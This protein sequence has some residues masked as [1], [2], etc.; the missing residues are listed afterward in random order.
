MTNSTIS[1]PNVTS[2]TYDAVGNEAKCVYPGGMSHTYSYNPQN[3]LLQVALTNNAGTQLQTYAYGLNATGARTNVTESLGTSVVRQIIYG[4]DGGNLPRVSRL[5]SETYYSNT[6]TNDGSQTYAYDPV[7]NRTNRTVSFGFTP[8]DNL[9]NQAF[10]FD[11]RDQIDSDGW[12]NNANP[13]YDLNGNSVTTNGVPDGAKYDAENR[14][15]SRGTNIQIT[16]DTDG[17]RI[18]KTVGG[19][20]TTYLVDDQNPTGYPQVLVEWTSLSPY[21]GT[22]ISYAYGLSLISQC[23][24]GDDI[25]Y[26]ASDGQGSTRMLL[27]GNTVAASFDY[28]GYG[29]LLNSTNST[30]SN[31]RYTGQQWDPDLQQYYLRA[32]Y[33]DPKLGR[34]WTIDTYDGDQTDPL[35]LHKYLYC[36]ANPA[37]HIDPSG[38]DMGDLM[39]SMGIGATIGGLSSAVANVAEGRAI[40]ARSV[41]E[42]AALGAV[43]GPLAGYIPAVGV[44]L[45]VGGAVY[46]GLSYGPTL[47]DPNATLEQREASAVL[48]FASIYGATAGMKYGEISENGTANNCFVS[49]TL[50]MEV[51]GYKK[52]ED[53]R[54]GDS[55]WSW[56]VEKGEII[57]EPVRRLFRRSVGELA[58]LRFGTNLLETTPQHRFW[59]NGSG[60]REAAN[61]CSGDVLKTLD[62]NNLELSSMTIE[63]S[64]NVVFNF[65]VK[66][67]HTYFVGDDNILTHNACARDLAGNLE[68]VGEPRPPGTDAHHIVARN[69]VR[70]TRARAILLREQIDL[71][72]AANGAFLDSSAHDGLHTDLYYETLCHELEGAL[73]GTVRARLLVIGQELKA[74]AYPH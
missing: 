50:I 68:A 51:D 48:I 32:R 65:E 34:F 35:S 28:D 74:G 8:Y 16:Y 53:V 22:S 39:I 37:N 36:E 58:I 46:S 1:S 63:L 29:N 6:G 41:F 17:N 4:Y 12:A 23:T 38:H 42:G 5:T 11:H 2:Y 24:D 49:G 59:V 14:L 15:I 61:L 9:T 19:I 71:D 33:Y 10:V 21:N 7:G 44:G 30:T 47:L 70:A 62:G 66:D 31:Y 45:G 72:D 43:L 55:V 25:L 57:V 27:D 56:D 40:T 52:I 67:T 60:W 54:I 18:S 64:S 20:T 26:F 73:P 69:D 13:N 3:R